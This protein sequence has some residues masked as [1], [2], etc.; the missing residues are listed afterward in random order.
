M[1]LKHWYLDEAKDDGKDLPGGGDDK[2][3]DA[4]DRGDAFPEKDDSH[5]D[6]DAKKAIDAELKDDKKDEKVDDKKADAGKDD[7][8]D[9]KKDVDDKDKRIRVPKYRLDEVTQR[10]RAREE[11]LLKELD[12]ARKAAKAPESS[13]AIEDLQKKLDDADDKYEKALL[14]GKAEDAARLR[15]ERRTLERQISRAEADALA[16]DK[17]GQAEQRAVDQLKYDMLLQR[18]EGDFPELNPDHE[19]FDEEKMSEV[20]DLLKAFG[21]T[22][23]RATA[24]Q[25]AVRYVMGPAKAAKGAEDTDKVDEAAKKRQEREEAARKAAADVAKKQPPRTDK[26]GKDSDKAGSDPLDGRSIFK[27]SQEEFAKLPSTTLS[28]LRGDELGT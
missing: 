15:T 9:D 24:L 16:G 4:I 2:K 26:V 3:D 13:K 23:S 21:A 7:K 11:Q 5:L 19:D 6:D 25:R 10:A 22:M 17:A 14:D 8:K 20:A 27:M 12:E 28:K 1:K 18:Y